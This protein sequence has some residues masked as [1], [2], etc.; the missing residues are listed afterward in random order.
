MKEYYL[1]T[2]PGIIYGN[3]LNI[4]AGFLIA[5]RGHF[6]Y[7]FIPTLLGS[8]LIIG[9]ACVFN[10]YFDRQI[11]RKMSRT[12]NRALVTGTVPPLNA[13][14][15]GTL[16]G[17]L[18]FLIL[19]T[20]TNI[21]TVVVGCLGFL[22]YVVV[23][24]FYKRHSPYGTLVGSISGAIPPVAGYTAVTNNL[25][26]AAVI[27]FFILVFWQMPHFYA[28]AIRRKAEYAAAKIPVMPIKKGILRTKLE[29]NFYILAYILSV[30]AL[31]YYGY[32]RWTYLIVITIFGCIWLW[33]GLSGLKSNTN[34]DD[35]EWARKM[36]YLSLV[37]TVAFFV[38]AS[39]GKLLP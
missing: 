13:L 32:A 33:L 18:G 15:F 6:E 19:L 30:M 39:A 11:D 24:T 20:Y 38:M 31:A 14:T 5:T 10:N 34:T 22:F 12:K 27:L 9:S 26:A 8:S 23:Y 2:K 29:M 35:V 28:I 36:F 37:I 21:L 16:L 25:D 4:T 17:T 1:L 3:A 7:L